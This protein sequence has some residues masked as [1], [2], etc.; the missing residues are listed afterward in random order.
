M[1]ETKVFIVDDDM[2]SAESLRALV[3]A[4]GYQ[5]ELFS[6]AESFLEAYDGKCSGC[7][8]L[9]IR[10]GGMSGLDLQKLLVSS[11]SPLAIVIISGHADESERRQA[12]SAGA[13]AVFDK[14]FAG[15]EFCELIRLEMTRQQQSQLRVK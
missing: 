13:I 15:S 8:V 9:D 6:S 7:L 14:P 3:N 11:R 1:V 10:L 12:K 2:A 5:T 4:I